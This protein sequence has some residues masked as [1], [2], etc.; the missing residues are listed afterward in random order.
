MT[1]REFV[2][3]AILYALFLLPCLGRDYLRYVRDR[4]ITHVHTEEGHEEGG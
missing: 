3:F 1:T 2:V 4:R